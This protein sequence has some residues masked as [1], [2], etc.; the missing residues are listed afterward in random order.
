VTTTVGTAVGVSVGAGS[1]AAAT[2]LPLIVGVQV[3]SMNKGILGS[4]PTMMSEVGK[5]VGWANL[6]F[7]GGKK[8]APGT[9]GKRLLQDDEGG[10]PVRSAGILYGAS[11]PVLL[12]GG[13]LH[14][15][16]DKKKKLPDV[17]LFPNLEIMIGLLLVNPYTKA[18]GDAFNTGSAGGC[19]LGAVMLLTLP[20]VMVGVSGWL[21]HVYVWKLRVVKFIVFDELREAVGV[22]GLVKRS[23]FTLNNGYWKD[24]SR[25]KFLERFGLLFKGVRGPI[26]QF[27]HGRMVRY[28]PQFKC[29]RWNTIDRVHEPVWLA[30]AR[31]QYTSFF[32]LRNILLSL[33]LTVVPN[34][35]AQLVL[36]L[37]L[38]SVHSVYMSGVVPLNTGNS[39]CVKLMSVHLETCVYLFALLYITTEKEVFESLV[40]AAQMTGVFVSILGS[41]TS[42]A[43]GLLLMIRTM[44][45]KDTYYKEKILGRIYFYK[46]KYLVHDQDGSH[47][48]TYE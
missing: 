21:V 2:A 27:T 22:M 7:G 20:L 5:G 45:R 26:F 25:A 18:A 47:Q 38:L 46:W 16:I 14:Y 40:F 32:V 33:L 15:V 29:Y 42:T 6:Q 43:C 30:Y 36:L 10:D 35:V 8:V 17:L 41:M 28:D 4:K 13:L 44:L 12:V 23:F 48:H 1:A 19:V 31:T 9:T 34:S 3:L 39:Q 11:F 37:V 24:N